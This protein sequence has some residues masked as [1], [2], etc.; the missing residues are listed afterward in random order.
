MT[1][2][3]Q[4]QADPDA[5]KYKDR[6]LRRLAP[7]AKTLEM[8]LPQDIRW[9]ISE[10]VRP[11]LKQIEYEHADVYHTMLFE[12][13]GRPEFAEMKDDKYPAQ[14]IAMQLKYPP[15]REALEKRR[16]YGALY[17]TFDGVGRRAYERG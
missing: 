6:W 2:A 10:A 14:E 15:L 9:R 3:K 5:Y 1:S 17:E 11:T 12:L 13:R 4:I 8:L 16:M 7:V